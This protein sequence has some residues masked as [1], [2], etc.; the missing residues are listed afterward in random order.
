MTTDNFRWSFSALN[1][2]LQCPQ[3]FYLQYV[4]R[5]SQVENAFSQYGTFTHSLL[6]KYAKDEIP[7]FALAEEYAA[8]FDEQVTAPFPPFPKGMGQKYYDQGLQYFESFQG[9][10]EQYEVLSAEEKFEILIG[11][12]TFVGLADL[13]LRDKNTGEIIVIDHKSKSSSSMAKDLS[14]YRRQL[15]LYAAYVKEKYGQ[16]PAYLKFNLFRENQWITEAFDLQVFK[17]TTQWAVETVQK[18][19]Q[20]T[21]W[22]V[23]P[24]SYFCRFVCGVMFDCPESKK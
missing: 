16:Y 14:M 6:E 3:M 4:Q 18:I 21:A 15:Y 17:K 19:L 20:E 13:I 23:K 7:D 5:C 12:Y 24:F 1:A 8:Q 22:P 11:G 2:Y 10:G 9:F